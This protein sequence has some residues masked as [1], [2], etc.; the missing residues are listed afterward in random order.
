MR[1]DDTIVAI[2]TAAGRA[3]R[4]IVR[5][6]G[7]GA[8]ALAGRVFLPAEGD[9]RDLG[10]F[11]SADG[12]LRIGGTLCN[13]LGPMELPARAYVFRSPRSFTRQDVVELHVPG[14][15][16]V[17]T[18]VEAALTDAGARRADAG[19]FT[20]RA[21]FSGRLDLS[22]AEAVADIIDAA[23]DAQLRCAV[24]ALG[25]RIAQL[26]R[27]SSEEIADVLAT[28]E[29][30]ID[31]AEEQI[32][33]DSPAAMAQRL[34]GQAQGIREL[35]RQAADM[36]ET[37]ETPHV[38]LCGYPNAG[39]SSLLNALCGSER[40]IVSPIAG[41]TRDVLTATVLLEGAG[42]VTFQDAAGFA[43]QANDLE[44]AANEAAQGAIA[45]ADV[46]LLVVDAQVRKGCPADLAPL[47]ALLA[48]I[49]QVNRRAK[50]LP[51]ANKID[52]VEDRADRLGA[53]AEALGLRATAIS[54]FTGEGLDELR[55]ELS[56]TLGLNATRSGQALGLHERQKRCF[57][58]A[59][60][61]A[62]RAAALLDDSDQLADRA[63]LVAVELREALAHLGGISGQ[64]VSEDILGRIF[65]RF[66]VG[67]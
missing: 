26:C 33:L 31:L 8:L 28:T 36:P 56:T 53:I 62:C 6:S 49:R 47:P 39:K 21:F 61:A 58:E 57:L 10:G 60:E 65:S 15:A 16:P 12:R 3:Q 32:E 30:S 34:R 7:P 23:D 45:A 43:L 64:I 48:R 51:M 18:A 66:C 29:A 44:A 22:A 19:E 17:A 1:T 59:A 24:G 54:A 14:S 52:L 41:T 27:Q 11:R 2:S 46:V 5:L 37:F 67:K 50:V 40:A 63:E 13:S 4:A 55:R 9:L 25:G 42:A 38:V 35:A 20:A